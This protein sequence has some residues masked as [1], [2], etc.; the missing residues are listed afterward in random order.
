[1]HGGGEGRVIVCG[2]WEV[3]L[4]GGPLAF[5]GSHVVENCGTFASVAAEGFLKLFVFNMV[6]C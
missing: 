2:G 5:G 1:M 4:R 3:A 6:V